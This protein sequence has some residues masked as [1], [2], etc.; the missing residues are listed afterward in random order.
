MET[1]KEETP[2]PV[3]ELTAETIGFLF[4]IRHDSG[5]PFAVHTKMKPYDNRVMIQLLKE[6]A[7][8]MQQAKDDFDAWD[9]KDGS[10]VAGREFFDAHKVEVSLNGTV[11][12]DEQFEKL[13]ARY[14]IRDA[15]IEHGYNGIHRVLADP[16]EELKK[17]DVDDIL[18]DTTIRM[19]FSLTDEKGQEQTVII[20]HAFDYPNAM[21]SL[22][23][24]RAQIQQGLR[25]GG[26][27]VAYNHE[28]LNTLYNKKI[29]AV[30]GL[31]INGQPCTKANKDEWVDLVPYLMKRAA[32]NFMFT[33]AE[34]ATRGNG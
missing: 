12:T 23:Y 2:V 6:R 17:L 22:A 14:N 20:E 10:V 33:R 21:D 11:L 19:N 34:R 27:R 32:L 25:A 4:R 18:G 9:V 3:Y 7:G 15:T 29:Q 5:K 26:F 1:M 16:E 8:F 13:D 31:V 30:L 28:A 24:E